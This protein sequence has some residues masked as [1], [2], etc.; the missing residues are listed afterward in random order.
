MI[1][2]AH[3]CTSYWLD[4]LSF[5]SLSIDKG[6]KGQKKTH[7][8]HFFRIFFIKTLSWWKLAQAAGS[9]SGRRSVE[10]TIR[11]RV[12]NWN[13]VCVSG[14]VSASTCCTCCKK[15]SPE[16]S[17]LN[18]SNHLMFPQK[19]KMYQ[20]CGETGKPFPSQH[21]TSIGCYV[22]DSLRTHFSHPNFEK[23]S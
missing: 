3:L 17:V 18:A 4:R 19:V 1:L 9:A 20:L 22:T 7:S 23:L 13:L 11:Q 2:S 16:S 8:D 5:F 14:S 21:N 12:G 15:E 6:T 10:E